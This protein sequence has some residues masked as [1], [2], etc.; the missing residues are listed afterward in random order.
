M[1]NYLDLFDRALV[2][3]NAKLALNSKVNDLKHSVPFMELLT[4]R[5]EEDRR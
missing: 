4:V 2:V 5:Y 3:H 1:M